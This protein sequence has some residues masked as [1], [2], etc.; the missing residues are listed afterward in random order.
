MA[1]S[2]AKK[3]R[4]RME[5]EGNYN[6]EL[7]RGLYTFADMRTRKT[8]TLK[9]KMYRVKHKERSSNQNHG[10]DEGSFCLLV[11]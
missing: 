1:K 2:K 10:Y 3:Y 4:E 5:R 11:M 7:N 8:K 6:P 9:D